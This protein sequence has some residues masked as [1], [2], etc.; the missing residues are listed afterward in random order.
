M[1]AIHKITEYLENATLAEL[2]D[3][4]ELAVLYEDQYPP[5]FKNV[6]LAELEKRE[7]KKELEE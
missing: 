2:M 7:I 6:I 5:F 4:L 3:E 1:E